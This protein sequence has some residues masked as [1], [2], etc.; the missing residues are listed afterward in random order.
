MPAGVETHTLSR[1]GGTLL[2]VN[3][4]F[5]GDPP[6]GDETKPPPPNLREK[7]DPWTFSGPPCCPRP[8]FPSGQD[9]GP[10]RGGATALGDCRLYRAPSAQAVDDNSGLLSCPQGELRKAGRGGGEGSFSPRENFAQSPCSLLLR[11]G[12]GLLSGVSPLR[13]PHQLL[14]VPDGGGQSS[15]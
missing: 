7:P 6:V 12:R 8:A 5:R 3:S 10:P 11:W 15:L 2:V 13:P 1:A 4:S 14:Q 9:G